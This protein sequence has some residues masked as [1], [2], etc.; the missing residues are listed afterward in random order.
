MSAPIRQACR[1]FILA[2]QFLT[3]I[4][5]PQIHDF[6][7]NALGRSS[8]YFPLIGLLI[9]GLLALSLCA[10]TM[11]DPWLAAILALTLWTFITG[12]LHLDGLS[13]LSDAL[14][15]SHR[16]PGRFHEVL[17]DPHVGTFGVVVLVIQLLLKLVLLMLLARTAQ[18]WLISPVCA[19]ARLGPLFWAHYLPVVKPAD[20]TTEG[21]GERFSWEINALVPWLWMVF[22]LLSVMLSPAFL[23]APVLLG[24]W[25]FYLHRRLGGQT[26]DA[27]GAGIEVCETILL[28][29]CVALL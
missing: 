25:A 1:S 28:F 13:D 26:G 14:G 27:L 9:G 8:G 29:A 17:K 4:P 7:P 5:T 16:D 11:V 2:V 20:A 24:L 21:S 3:R 22:L 10:G 19:W 15:A 23:A 18:A 12:A 6:Q